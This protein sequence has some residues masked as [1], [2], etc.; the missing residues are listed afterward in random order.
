MGY[1]FNQWKEISKIESLGNIVSICTKNQLQ[2]MA[3]C[4][5]TAMDYDEFI[6]ELWNDTRQTLLMTFAQNLR[7][8]RMLFYWNSIKRFS[9]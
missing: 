4:W 6:T 2:Y 1:D 8:W 7:V 3:Y 5:Y 9:W